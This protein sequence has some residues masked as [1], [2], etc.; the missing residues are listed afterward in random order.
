MARTISLLL[1]RPSADQ[2]APLPIT[3]GIRPKFMEEWNHQTNTFQSPHGL[4]VILHIL[5]FMRYC[6]CVF[7]FLVQ[8][9][10]EIRV[11]TGYEL[12]PLSCSIDV[13]LLCFILHSS[14]NSPSSMSD[15]HNHLDTHS[16]EEQPGI[17]RICGRYGVGTLLGCGTFGES[18]WLRSFNFTEP[19]PRRCLPWAGY[20]NGTGCH[21]KIWTYPITTWSAPSQ[22][23][24]LQSPF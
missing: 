5:A 12:K 15:S 17:V 13:Q 14:P 2:L 8:D 19:P 1:G 6:S 24:C 23:S 16:S 11:L 7:S 22:T 10:S 4:H 3:S 21:F 18:F 9:S 20:Q